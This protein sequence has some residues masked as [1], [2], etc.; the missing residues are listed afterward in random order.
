MIQLVGRFGQIDPLS[1]FRLAEPQPCSPPPP[2]QVGLTT[3][4]PLLIGPPKITFSTHRS[5][6][7][8]TCSFYIYYPSVHHDYH[9]SFCLE[10]HL[11]SL[12]SL[13]S[14]V[15]VLSAISSSLHPSFF[16]RRRPKFAY[17]FSAESRGNK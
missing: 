16:T 14:L 6:N 5:H 17:T 3:N 13:C 1:S 8:I 2:P 15:T 12:H 7:S 10:L 9:P 11:M 4:L